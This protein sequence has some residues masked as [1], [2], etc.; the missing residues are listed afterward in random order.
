MLI[1]TIRSV[2]ISDI[3]HF[4]RSS[5]SFSI[6]CYRNSMFSQET[7]LVNQKVTWVSSHRSGFSYKILFCLCRLPYLSDGEPTGDTPEKV[8]S[9]NKT[10]GGNQILTLSCR[11]PEMRVCSDCHTYELVQW[12]TSPPSNHIFTVSIMLLL[13]SLKPIL[14][15]AAAE[16]AQDPP[17]Q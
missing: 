5:F 3:V 17:P 9:H 7:L 2:S 12:N 10:F 4:R 15:R 16:K 6:N 1:I 8:K 13:H 14:R 11:K